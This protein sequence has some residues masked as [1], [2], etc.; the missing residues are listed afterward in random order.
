MK[1][2]KKTVLSFV[3]LFF[4]VFYLSRRVAKAPDFTDNTPF[5]SHDAITGISAEAPDFTDNTPF[6]S[7]DAITGISIKPIIM[8][9][10]I[11][12][13]GPASIELVNSVT[14]VS[15]EK[16][17]KK[18]HQPKKGL[19]SY[20]DLLNIFMNISQAKLTNLEHLPNNNDKKFGILLVVF[21]KMDSQVYYRKIYNQARMIR[22]LEPDINICL[23]YPNMDQRQLAVFGHVV[24]QFK[25]IQIPSNDSLHIADAMMLS[26]YNITIFFS[27]DMI[28]CKPFITDILPF[29][30]EKK[31][32]IVYGGFSHDNSPAII[33]DADSD[34]VMYRLDKNVLRIL[35]Q[36]KE[37]NATFQQ[38]V[39]N[40]RYELEIGRFSPG[41]GGSLRPVSEIRMDG[42]RKYS[43]YQS[44]LILDHVRF[45][46]INSVNSDN[47][48]FNSEMC[49]FL[50]FYNS[51]RSLTWNKSKN[52]NLTSYNLGYSLKFV[53]SEEECELAFNEQCD[54]IPWTLIEPIEI[55]N[56]PER[57]VNALTFGLIYPIFDK[58]YDKYQK[59][60]KEIVNSVSL[61]RNIET[62]VEITLISH[63]IFPDS[64]SKVSNVFDN[65]ILV[66]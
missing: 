47:P 28:F 45:F 16:N 40:H 4:F 33:G 20:D 6:L 31:L 37:K 21:P 62:K 52:P 18:I 23:L 38:A 34:V 36:W 49:H 61:V 65:I 10:D 56:V 2:R 63:G 9:K 11:V 43:N 29:F 1:F 51:P 8:M 13:Y 39:Y 30:E 66:I 32:D 35:S 46:Q 12:N 26:P 27:K 24:N 54:N 15:V 19:D 17:T 59:L 64:L 5:L 48:Y 44:L 60:M 55:F 22:A 25:Q 58:D 14:E 3:S 7:H 57:N 53:D 50:N 41:F 42:E